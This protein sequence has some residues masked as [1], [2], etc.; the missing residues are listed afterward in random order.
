M[1]K[2]WSIFPI[3]TSASEYRINI[4][5][6][7][8]GRMTDFKDKNI[9]ITGGA[10][11]IG[12]QMALMIAA[13]KGHVIIWDIDKE[14]MQNVENEIKKSGGF[15]SSYFCDLSVRKNI[16]ETAEIVKKEHGVVDVLINNAGIVTGKPFLELSDELI[17][18]AFAVNTL[19]YFWTVKAFLPD[20]IKQNSGHIVT[21]SSAGGLIGVNRLSDY[22][23]SKFAVFGFD[24]SLRMEFK[25]RRLN[26]KTTVVCPYYINTGMFEGVKTRFPSILPIIDEKEASRKIV[27]SIKKDKPRLF[28]PPIVYTVPLLR[29]LP[30]CV[31]D[32]VASFLGINKSME[33]FKGK[34]NKKGES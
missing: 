24:E 5:C 30:V 16:Y 1:L 23:A 12:R 29:C 18:K 22:C 13:E 26:I 19:A 34:A 33:E 32:W 20:M 8:G 11:G 3:G 21:I 6:M 4:V 31:F 7:K 27:K 2:R 28:I 14:K 9:L 15:A 10:S 25:A 17:E